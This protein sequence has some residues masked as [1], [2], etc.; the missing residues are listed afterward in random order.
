MA[1]IIHEKVANGLKR[2][3]KLDVKQKEYS[4]EADA[5]LKTSGV[6]Q[7]PPP[8]YKALDKA[9]EIMKKKAKIWNEIRHYLICGK[10]LW[11][12]AIKNNLSVHFYGEEEMLDFTARDII[13]FINSWK[14]ECA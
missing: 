9:V 11:Q 2:I 14:E 4:D 5:I 7:A 12:L 1:G 8:F 10:T 13:K 3:E 6:G